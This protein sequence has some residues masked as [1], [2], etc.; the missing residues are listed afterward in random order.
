MESLSAP[1]PCKQM[2]KLTRNQPERT[3]SGLGYLTVGKSG[4]GV[5]CASTGM[6][7]GRPNA[8][9]ARTVNLYPTPVRGWV[10]Q[11]DEGNGYTVH[12]RVCQGRKI[13]PSSLVQVRVHENVP[14]VVLM[15][16]GK[17]ILAVGVSHVEVSVPGVGP[18]HVE[19]GDAR[20]N[21]LVVRR[22]DLGAVGPVHLV[23]VVLLGVV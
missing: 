11:C 1:L 6:S 9:K 22:V 3:S 21:L 12:G 2:S 7:G 20:C 19:L 23:P 13:A 10:I 8:S 5:T 18:G 14:M 15:D 4:S 17:R 16:K